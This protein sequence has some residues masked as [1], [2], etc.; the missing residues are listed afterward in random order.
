MD[1][2]LATLLRQIEDLPPRPDD[3]ASLVVACPDV[4]T[5]PP[6]ELSWLVFALME[7]EQRQAWAYKI[8][9][10]RVVRPLLRQHQGER[11]RNQFLDSFEGGLCPASRTG[12][13]S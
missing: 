12:P 11:S 8:V 13:I 1:L 5:L 2:Q 10:R 9:R 4:G 7:F 6:P 3:L